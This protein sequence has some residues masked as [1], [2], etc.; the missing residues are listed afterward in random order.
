MEEEEEEEVDET[1]KGL[2]ERTMETRRMRCGVTTDGGVSL[3]LS[4]LSR[5]MVSSLLGVGCKKA[6]GS[7]SSMAFFG[8][9]AG[10]GGKCGRKYNLLQ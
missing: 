8:R 1:S 6:Q 3:G 10:G 2:R 5:W 7:E 4:R 9:Q